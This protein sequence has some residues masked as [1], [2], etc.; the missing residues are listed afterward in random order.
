VSPYQNGEELYLN[1][2]QIIP[3]PG[4]ADYMI[5]IA[6]KEVAGQVE[7]AQGKTRH[8]LRRQFWIQ[9]LELARKKP[10]TFFEAASPSDRN[11]VGAVVGGLGAIWFSMRFSF[12]EL[13]VQLYCDR[14]EEENTF[15][16]ATL[17]KYRAQIDADF[18][19]SLV[20]DPMPNNKATQIY[21]VKS[22][23]GRNQDDWPEMGQWLVDTMARLELAMRE[24]LKNVRKEFSALRGSL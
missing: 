11:S 19:G 18:G 23:D 10:L 1:V 24:P 12:S 14:K 5:G 16:F 2:D 15:I 6:E 4:A 3:P 21:I 17:E 9:T 13:R 22:C 7:E 20:W 8:D